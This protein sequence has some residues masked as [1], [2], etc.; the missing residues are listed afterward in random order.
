M[1]PDEKQSIILLLIFLSIVLLS[2]MTNC[3]ASRLTPDPF[4]NCDT[5]RDLQPKVFTING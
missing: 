1:K 4:E 2:V 5:I 3:T